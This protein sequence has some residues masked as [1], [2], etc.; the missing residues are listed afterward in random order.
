M[1]EST[2]PR[3]VRGC[4]HLP[5]S[6]MHMTLQAVPAGPRLHLCDC[7]CARRRRDGPRLV[8]RRGTL[9]FNYLVHILYLFIVIS[10]LYLIHTVAFTGFGDYRLRTAIPKLIPM[11]LS[12]CGSRSCV[13]TAIAAQIL[14]PA[15]RPKTTQDTAK[16]ASRHGD[17]L[18]TAGRQAEDRVGPPA[19]QPPAQS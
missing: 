17:S 2:N 12:R 18:K 8:C 14:A 1:Q 3:G 13:Q 19:A 6:P 7:P 11:P 9:C 10:Y 15:P 5:P 16:T 4:D